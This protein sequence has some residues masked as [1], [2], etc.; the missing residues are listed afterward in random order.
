MNYNEDSYFISENDNEKEIV[1]SNSFIKKLLK[2][3]WLIFTF[4]N[5]FIK[6]S[7]YSH[8]LL[9]CSYFIKFNFHH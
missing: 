4:G 2:N 9:V 1:E 3:S 7:I 6:K 8:I 5:I